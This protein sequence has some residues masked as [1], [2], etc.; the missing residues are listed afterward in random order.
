MRRVAL[1][2]ALTLAR[3]VFV[4]LLLLAARGALRAGGAP[5]ADALVALVVMAFGLTNG[6]VPTLCMVAG[7]ALAARE[8]RGVA[9]ML[10]VFFLIAG[11]MLGALAG[12]AL[13]PLA[14]A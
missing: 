1:I 8:H 7:P 2:E 14:K 12:A 4:P 10:H 3:F 9:S 6:H 13:E 11:L 5:Q